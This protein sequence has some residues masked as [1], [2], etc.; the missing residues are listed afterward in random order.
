[1]AKK[2]KTQFLCNECGDT[3]QRWLG[4]CSCGAWNSLVEF[5]E[6]KAVTHRTPTA[7]A[8]KGYSKQDAKIENL[9]QVSDMNLTRFDTGS[10]EFN[11]VLG[12]A[13]PSRLTT[14]PFQH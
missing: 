5:K 3:H 1:M 14:S 6:A 13:Y 12:S 10:P 9:S 7:K 11:R 8:H 4:Q 2:E